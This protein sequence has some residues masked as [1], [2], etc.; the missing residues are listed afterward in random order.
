MIVWLLLAGPVSADQ[1]ACG[2]QTDKAISAAPCQTVMAPPL[3]RGINLTNWFRFPAS[4]DP[5]ALANYM[6]DQALKDLHA[7][8]FDFVRLAVDPDLAGSRLTNLIAALRRI[9]RQGL[10][11]IVSPHP[12]GWSL[13]TKAEDRERLRR[14]W[15]NLAP[16]LR[17]LDPART[18]PEVLNEPVFPGDPAGWAD[19]QH[20]VLAEIRQALPQA[21]VVLTGHD[22]G[23]IGGLLALTPES[24]PNVVYSF[25]LYDPAELTSLAAYRPGLD[26]GALAQLP[27]PVSDRTDCEAAANGSAD[28]PTQELMRYYCALGWDV[29]RMNGI[30]QQAADWARV[31]QVRILAG[32]F[33][34]SVQ[35]NQ[36]ARTAWLQTVRTGCETKGI[37]WALWG[38]DDVMGFAIARPPAIRPAL[39]R[40][41]LTALG[42]T[43]ANLPADGYD[44]GQPRVK[45]TRFVPTSGKGRHRGKDR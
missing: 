43:A 35:L 32:E 7:V 12:S 34:A 18:V 15:H 29:A 10:T 9:Q 23:S 16:A 22:W 37:G 11:V 4:R 2:N 38:Y 1:T 26:R 42:L 21:T 27:F 30:I 24:D 17:L 40:A 41:V 44:A 31:H 6:T 5:S 33:G 14:F 8:G 3:S 25:H 20:V 36:P 45:S 39:D 13:E 19:L 28:A